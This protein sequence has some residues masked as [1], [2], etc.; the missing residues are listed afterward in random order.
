MKVSDLSD[1]YQTIQ[2]CRTCNSNELTEILNLGLHPLA[3]SLLNDKQDSEVMAPLVLIRCKNCTTIQLSINVRPELMFQEYLWVTGTTETA[4]KHC[5]ELA[6]T[7]I[8]TFEDKHPRVLEIG[9]NDGTLLQALVDN[10]AEEV[11]GV[12]PA[13]NLQPKHLRG[14]IKL[15]EGFFSHELASRLS[16]E[17]PAV[18]I[19]VARNVLSHVPNLNNVMQGINEVISDHGMVVIEFHEASKI[20]TELHYES[21]YHEHTFYHSIKSIQAALSQIGFTI[22]DVSKS[23][24]SGGSHVIYASRSKKT[25]TQDL[26]MALQAEETL[27][28]YEE[29]AW[30]DFAARATSNI[31]ELREIFSSEANSRWIAFGASARSSTLLNTIG[32]GSKCLNQI[33]DNNPLKQG[34]FSPGIRLQICNPTES[35]DSTVEKVFICA[36]NFEDEIIEFLTKKLK[37]NGEV[38]LPLP[39]NIRRFQI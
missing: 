35:I 28:V 29:T 7:I 20:L 33:A 32:E 5:N 8:E 17:I 38:I 30:L 37:W 36:F 31:A 9:S 13:S 1:I 12:D 3:N 6:K 14:H 11:I 24:I 26:Q 2:N 10:G 19:V 34:K 39:N 15:V 16:G 4:K 25:L 23:P 27:G 18:D 21:I 22:F